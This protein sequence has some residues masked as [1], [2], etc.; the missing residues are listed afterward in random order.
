MLE[1]QEWKEFGQTPFEA[2]IQKIIKAQLTQVESKDRVIGFE[3]RI[4]WLKSPENT[5]VTLTGY[6]NYK[7][8]VVTSDEIGKI[9]KY[10][11]TNVTSRRLLIHNMEAQLSDSKI[12][13]V[14]ISVNIWTPFYGEERAFYRCKHGI[15]A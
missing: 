14:G 3:N 5:P 2:E 4:L 9:F 1:D 6:A 8:S 12:K 15:F 13:S 11:L 10:I 7:L